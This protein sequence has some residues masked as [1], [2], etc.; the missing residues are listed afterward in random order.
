VDK[1]PPD[2]VVRFFNTTVHH[3]DV[4]DETIDDLATEAAR[5]AWQEEDMKELNNRT[6]QNK[7]KPA[8]RRR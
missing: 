1:C 6:L 3:G 5:A 8:P 4:I 2:A 7:V